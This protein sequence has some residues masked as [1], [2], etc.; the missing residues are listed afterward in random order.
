MRRVFVGIDINMIR[1]GLANI[2]DHHSGSEVMWTRRAYQFARPS[3]AVVYYLE[4][5]KLLSRA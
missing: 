5:I 2:H 4:Y 1:S 3:V